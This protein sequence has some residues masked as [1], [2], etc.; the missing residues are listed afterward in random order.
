M[1]LQA[2]SLGL[3]L[4]VLAVS[5]AVRGDEPQPKELLEKAIAAHGGKE[6]LTKLQV[7]VSQIKGTIHSPEGDLAFSGEAATDGAKRERATLQL[8]IGGMKFDVASV[9]AG[10]RGWIK[11]ND[12]VVDMD[13]DKL[14]Q[15][16]EQA[17]VH[18]VATLTPLL[19]PDYKLAS[20]GELK[21]GDKPALGIIVSRAERQD[22]QI[23]FDKET[24]LLVKTEQRVKDDAGKEVT[25][26]SVFSDHDP[27][28][29]R[30]PR[31]VVVK[32]DDKPY[33]E[34]EVTSFDPRE[35]LDDS[36]FQRP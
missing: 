31:K 25:E 36:L 34:A 27:K 2:K 12:T 19:G 20:R 23:F 28:G 30:Q 6:E 18:M 10:D 13:D 9:W 8:E 1:R 26:E 24:H 17:H 21:V 33:L 35:K 29:A 4:L 16:R 32:R 11:F 22:V 14:Q 5:T 7:G 15:A 3:I